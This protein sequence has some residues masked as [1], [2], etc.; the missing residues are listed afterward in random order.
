[1]AGKDLTEYL[2][3]MLK[4]KASGQINDESSS[5]EQVK[6]IKEKMCFVT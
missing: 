6:M 3:T 1:L 4:E 5:Y 2:H